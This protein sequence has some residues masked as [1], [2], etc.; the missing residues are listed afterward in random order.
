VVGGLW[1]FEGKYCLYHFSPE[2]GGKKLTSTHQTWR[3]HNPPPKKGNMNLHCCSENLKSIFRLPEQVGNIL[4]TWA[5]TSFLKSQF[6]GIIFYDHS[7]K[8][9]SSNATQ[10]MYNI[11]F[12]LFVSQHVSTV[13]GHHQVNT[14]VYQILFNCNP[15]LYIFWVALVSTGIA[16]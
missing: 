14:T 5:T 16:E 12:N 4:I 7:F 2:D 13:F 11:Q 3:F 8:P 10:R 1:C 6:L 15:M 9:V